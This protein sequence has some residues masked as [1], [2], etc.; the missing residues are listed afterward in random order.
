MH[1][2][3]QKWP[4]CYS[5]HES[6]SQ[7]LLLQIVTSTCSNE[8]ATFLIAM[9]CNTW[10]GLHKP[11][12]Q[13]QKLARFFFSFD[14]HA[15]LVCGKLHL[16][17]DRCDWYRLKAGDGSHLVEPRRGKQS[18]ITHG[19]QNAL[20]FFFL[21]IILLFFL[22]TV[23]LRWVHIQLITYLLAHHNS[24][25]ALHCGQIDPVLFLTVCCTTATCACKLHQRWQA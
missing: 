16:I 9:L 8:A 14:V 18:A 10:D 7:K 22:H 4:T 11:V 20:P 12:P 15:F 2:T 6:C 19:Y 23:M 3:F 17:K 1:A 25:V 21:C 13:G 24:A 5:E